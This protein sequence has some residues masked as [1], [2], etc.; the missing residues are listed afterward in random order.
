MNIEKGLLIMPFTFA[1]KAGL[2]AITK[3]FARDLAPT[4]KVNAVAPGN[5]RATRC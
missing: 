4:I 2:E 1:A 5:I 3:V